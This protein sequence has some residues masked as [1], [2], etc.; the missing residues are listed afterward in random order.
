MA[1][2]TS[3]GQIT[4]PKDVRDRLGLEAGVEVEL[5]VEG[6]SARLR[7]IVAPD[8]LDRWVGALQLPEGVDD[9]VRQ[10]RDEP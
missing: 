9:F 8:A 10:L 5:V 1:R 3:K 2:V 6:T 7:K 4:I